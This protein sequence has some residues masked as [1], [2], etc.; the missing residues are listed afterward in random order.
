MTFLYP[1]RLWLLTALVPL[2]ILTL[3]GAIRSRRTVVAMVGSYHR[4]D[5]MA[6]LTIKSFLMTVLQAASLAMVLLAAAGPQWG[7]VSIEDERRGIDMVFL[8]DVSNSMLI[9]DI[10]PSRLARSRE[11]A[12]ALANRLEG[13]HAAV[14]VFKG[15]AVTI[16][17][18]TD[19][20][21]SLDLAINNLSP[22]LLTAPGTSIHAG[23]QE[24]LS[25]FPAGSPRHRIVLMLSDGG[26]EPGL[27]SETVNLLRRSEVPV[28]TVVAG[29]RAGGTIPM[30]GGGVVR[31]ALGNA[32]ILPAMGQR[33]QQIAELSGG[34]SYDLGDSAVVQRIAAD[35]DQAAGGSAS[36]LF[37]QVTVERYHLFVL[38]ALVLLVFSIL[39]Q[40]IRWKGLL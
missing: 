38:A 23:L 1:E 4:R 13:L 37:R 40:T 22:A 34:R 32:V 14:V 20:S 18:M 26:H 39:V 27:S 5:V 31:D 29:T 21:V 28:W 24:A 12:R 19:D 3:L 16:V 15:A 8:V 2:G 33:M 30:A 17:P 7:D 11:V 25:A 35:A 36:I 9:E 6:I 10:A